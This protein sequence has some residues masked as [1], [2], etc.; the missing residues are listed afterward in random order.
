MNRLHCI[1][2]YGLESAKIRGTGSIEAKGTGDI[3]A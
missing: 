3:S 1:V 2:Q